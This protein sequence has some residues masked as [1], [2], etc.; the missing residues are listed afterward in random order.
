MLF[1]SCGSISIDFSACGL[2]DDDGGWDRWDLDFIPLKRLGDAYC[3]DLESSMEMS[4]PQNLV[5][6]KKL[7]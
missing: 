7:V 4:D 1:L 2:N 3:V 5:K 6:K